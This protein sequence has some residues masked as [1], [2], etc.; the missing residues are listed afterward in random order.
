MKSVPR[1]FLIALVVASISFASPSADGA[2]SISVQQLT[3]GLSSPVALTHA[4]DGSGRIFITEQGGR[5]RIFEQGSLLGAPYLDIDPLVLTGGEQG[6]LS[7]AFHPSYETNGY[8]FVYY[9]NNSG[10]NVVARYQAS[11]PSA[12]TVNAATGEVI[13]TINHPVNTNH[14]GGQL[15]FGPDGYLYIGPGDGGGGGDTSNN[16]Q[17]LSTLLGKILRLDVD[18]AFPYAIP[19][20][21]PFADG[22]GPNRDEIWHYGLRNPWRFSFDRLTGEMF[23]GDVGQA[24]WEEIS[25]APAEAGGLNFG[26]RLMEGNH[27]FNP[28]TNCNPGGLT[29]PI[30]EYS[31]QSGTVECSVTGGY[32]HRGPS[33]GL[34][35]FYFFG[36]YCSGKVWAGERAGNSWNA[37]QLLDTTMNI[38]SFG[39][40]EAGEVYVVHHGGSVHRIVDNAPPPTCPVAGPGAKVVDQILPEG[41]TRYGTGT[42]ILLANPS[43]TTQATANITYLTTFGPVCPASAQGIT[44]EAGQRRTVDVNT[45]LGQ[46]TKVGA[47]VEIYGTSAVAEVSVHRK[48]SLSNVDV[49]AA[50]VAASSWTIPEGASHSGFATEISVVNPDT[51]QDTHVDFTFLRPS[52]SVSPP[53]MQDVT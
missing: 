53:A 12:D 49:T 16:A 19:P 50:P 41:E 47:L 35:G 40:D 39:E 11:P 25:L 29:L 37:P 20:G 42:F 52:G 28:S 15:A 4:G 21:N 43:A 23:I 33:S 9:T 7:V 48:G 17:T 1:V 45:T 51:T 38:S 3:A 6:L 30:I 2:P 46:V 10:N 22:G 13:L 32:V 36:D 27:C 18:S 44:I 14:N 24:S 8:F 31:S 26:W 5:I 34:N